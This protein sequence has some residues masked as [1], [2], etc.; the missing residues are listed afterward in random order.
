LCRL[1][2]ED[3]WTETAHDMTPSHIGGSM[4]IC[5]LVNR[6]DLLPW[7][8]LVGKLPKSPS[9]KNPDL[10]VEVA[11]GQPHGVSHSP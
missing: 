1:S 5:L 7:Q 2:V 9:M 4:W 10:D 3:E 8:R 6:R 11:G